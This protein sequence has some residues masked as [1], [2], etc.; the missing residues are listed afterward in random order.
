VQGQLKADLSDGKIGGQRRAT[1][2]YQQQKAANQNGNK[3]GLNGLGKPT[4]GRAVDIWWLLRQGMNSGQEGSGPAKIKS[5]VAPLSPIYG[6]QAL[7]SG[8]LAVGCS[9]LVAAAP[10][11]RR[12]PWP[13]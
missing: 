3:G 7:A 11:T 13:A 6:N 10:I 12:R 2:T 1:G 9:A 5:R 8:A 4:K